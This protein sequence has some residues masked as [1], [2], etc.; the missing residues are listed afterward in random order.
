MLS[1]LFIDILNPYFLYMQEILFW[2]RIFCIFVVN[3][4]CTF[5]WYFQFIFFVCVGD[6]ILNSYLLYICS[7]CYRHFFVDLLNFYFFFVCAG[8]C[9]LNSHLMF[10][11]RGFS[12]GFLLIF[13]API[14]C[15]YVG[16]CILNLYLL[17]I[18]ICLDIILHI[19]E[20]ISF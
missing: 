16:D 8:D 18:C 6:C 3:F 5:Y 20:H 2:I 9:S 11:W 1:A 4:I 17:R 19:V 15:I 14:F 10:I 7:R 13:W 12:L